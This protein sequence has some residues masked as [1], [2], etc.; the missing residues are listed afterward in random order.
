MDCTH[1]AYRDAVQTCDLVWVSLYRTKLSTA[2]SATFFIHIV[3]L[4]YRRARPAVGSYSVRTSNYEG[5]RA[6]GSCGAARGG[7]LGSANPH[8]STPRIA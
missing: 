4:I 3:L 5:M 6:E 8:P 1:R 7:G 2:S